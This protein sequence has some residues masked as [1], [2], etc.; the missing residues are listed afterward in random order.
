MINMFDI[1]LT[2]HITGALAMGALSLPV[3]L[4]L[5]KSKAALTRISHFLSVLFVFQSL[6]GGALGLISPDPSPARMCANFALYL[7]AFILVQAI[8]AARLW[9]EKAPVLRYARMS[10]ITGTAVFAGM[11]LF[12]V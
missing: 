7:L 8:I 10:A 1:T 11:F 3:I 12:L 4:P 5:I 6:S 2:S 9:A